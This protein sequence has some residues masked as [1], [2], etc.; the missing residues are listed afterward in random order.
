[1][2]DTLDPVDAPDAPDTRRRPVLVATVVVALLSGFLIAVFAV[3]RTGGGDTADTPL[4]GRPAPAVRGT[5]LDGPSFDLGTR[6]GS[7]VVLNFFASWCDPCKQEAPDLARFAAEQAQQPDGA[8]VVGV[9]YNDSETEIRRF[10]ADY[11]GGGYP[12]V[13]DPDGRF[14][15]S[16]GVV[17][18]PE[19]WIVDPNGIVRA[20]VISTVTTESLTELLQRAK[21]QA[22]AAAV[23]P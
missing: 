11:G 17:K 14:A 1:M 15:I 12:A 9:V 7:W 5:T 6:R 4:L 3:S 23:Q 10:L 18:V 16:Y 13:L 22:G 19:T 2:A 20:R 8:E 21:A